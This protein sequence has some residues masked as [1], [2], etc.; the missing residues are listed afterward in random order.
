MSNK[1]NDIDVLKELKADLQEIR[2]INNLVYNVNV[3][4]IHDMRNDL[5]IN[6]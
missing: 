5:K 4:L 3:A 1:K 2:D 6:K